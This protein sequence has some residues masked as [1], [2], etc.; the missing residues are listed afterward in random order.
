MKRS[1]LFLIFALCLVACS[2]DDSLTDVAGNQAVPLTGI[3]AAV[4]GGTAKRAPALD[5]DYHVGRSVFVNADQMVLTC[6]KRTQSPI[7]GFTYTDIVFNHT[8]GEGQTTG[9]WDRDQNRGGTEANPTQVPDAIYWSDATN[10][11]TYIGYSLP[12]PRETF[13]WTADE[14]GIYSGA[15]RSIATVTEN[16]TTT[17]YIDHTTDAKLKADDLLLT[18]D[19]DKVSETGGSVAKLYFYHALA[20]VRIIVNIMGFSA[21]N[22]AADTQSKV[23]N[24]VLKDMPVRYRWMQNSTGVS[25]L[26][27]EN[28][29]TLP[30]RMWIPRSAGTGTGMGRQFVFYALA[31]PR[32]NVTQ[33]MTFDVTY[34]DPMNPN[35]SIT[36]SYT[37]SISPIEY[38]AGYCTTIHV[39]LNHKNEELT[40]G[41]EY[42]DWQFVETPDNSELKKNTVLLTA[43]MLERSNFTLAG[44]PK[45]NEDDAT[46]LY[47][48]PKTGKLTDIYG[49]DGSAAAPFSI[50]TASQLV[51]FAHEVKGT[52]R[53]TST[54]TRLDGTQATLTNG[55]DFTDYY[56]HLDADIVLQPS[57]FAT[58]NQRVKWCSIGEGDCMFNGKFLGS[59]RTIRHL[60]GSPFFD[61]LGKDAVVENLKITEVIEVDGR[62]LVANQG[63]GMLAGVYAEGTIRQKKPANEAIYSGS[64]VGTVGSKGAIIGCAHV[65]DVEAWATGEGV[66]GGLVGYNQGLLVSCYH[67]GKEKNLVEGK[68]KYHTY[69]GVGKY[70]DD[71]YAFSCYFNADADPEKNDVEVLVH[72]KHCFPVSVELMMS[73]PFVNSTTN[74]TVGK[75]VDHSELVWYEQHMSLNH[76]LDVF[77]EHLSK[78]DVPETI[79]NPSHI[80]WFKENYQTYKF[81]YIP[82]TFPR[83]Y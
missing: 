9:G 30:N 2:S 34:P 24:M 14:H 82:G 56:V 40:V 71:A 60:Y 81:I 7:P 36:R 59:H 3:D 17:R 39:S 80:K 41:A 32:T 73:N 75:D 38:R 21:S 23:K 78:N 27:E 69:A 31:I 66:I 11:H 50:T 5:K 25:V 26:P 8:V 44:D 16:E 74:L 64:L 35:D 4:S 20:N 47:I 67:S 29:E 1:F 33:T 77:Y 46:W 13:A 22:E 15:L 65:G 83:A 55:F 42:M 12:Q 68:E 28:N 49:N 62:G 53:V 63:D 61:R 79:Y 6:I 37:A 58:A 72:G 48:D 43:D 18:Y 57:L 70:D 45:A 52:N 76:A 10:P 54:Y 51:S 19:T